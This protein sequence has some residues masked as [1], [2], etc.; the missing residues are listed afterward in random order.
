MKN[1]SFFSAPPLPWSLLQLSTTLRTTSWFFEAY[2]HWRPIE[3]RDELSKWSVIVVCQFVHSI[4]DEFHCNSFPF[5]VL[6]DL[7]LKMPFQSFWAETCRMH[8]Q[9]QGANGTGLS[10]KITMVATFL[11]RNGIPQYLKKK[12]CAKNCCAKLEWLQK[13][14][15]CI[16]WE[17]KPVSHPSFMNH[18]QM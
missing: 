11:S 7:Y 16:P 4:Q 15:S 13:G 6:A 17:K 9:N 1:S 14:T 5:P 3:I 8:G 10:T 2:S 12:P 18:C